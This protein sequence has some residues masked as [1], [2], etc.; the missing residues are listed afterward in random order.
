MLFEQTLRHVTLLY[1]NIAGDMSLTEWKNLFTEARN[2]DY[3]YL[4]IDKIG[5]ILN[6]KNSKQ[7]EKS[8]VLIVEHPEAKPSYQIN[9]NSS[10][11]FFTINR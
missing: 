10:S 1:H 4:V 8:D 9:G 7:N 3:N 2:D 5:E 6:I 11:Y